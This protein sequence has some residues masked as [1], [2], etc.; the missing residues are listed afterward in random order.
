LLGEITTF[1]VR[2]WIKLLPGFWLIV[3]ARH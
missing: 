2:S 1:W 3:R